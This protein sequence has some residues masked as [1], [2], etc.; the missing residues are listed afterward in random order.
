MTSLTETSHPRP[1]G[2]TTRC[3]MVVRQDHETRRFE[4]L[5][6]LTA[7]E[8]GGFT[9]R[10][11]PDVAAQPDFRP[12]PGFADP[13]VVYE[14]DEL[15]PFFQNRVMSPRREDYGQLLHAV[16]LASDEDAPVEL[17]IRTAG[18]RATDTFQIVPHPTVVEAGR[19]QRL[20]LVSGIRHIGGASDAVARLRTGQRLTLRP[21]P[22]NPHDSRA[23][24]LDTDSGS[25]IGW[26]PGY[27]CDYVHEHQAAGG[28]VEV[29]V[30]QANGPDVPRHLQLLCRMTV[31]PG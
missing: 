15:F 7:H 9:F 19:E 6:D 18:R 17:L 14:A 20:F 22:S 1:A 2:T 25:P 5:G 8:S 23:V 27:L 30:V 13:T 31:T 10:Y 28:D 12:I 24:L 4:V 3:L 11:R 21:E 16:G 26:V 29:T